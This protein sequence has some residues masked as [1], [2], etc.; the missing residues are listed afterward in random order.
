VSILNWFNLKLDPWIHFIDVLSHHKDRTQ[1]I[2]LD[3][4]TILEAVKDYFR[5]V[6]QVRSVRL[7]VDINPDLKWNADRFAFVFFDL[8]LEAHFVFFQINGLIEAIPSDTVAVRLAWNL[9]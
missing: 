1:S 9:S 4:A 8:P 5:R 3:Y 7:E 2:V 6:V